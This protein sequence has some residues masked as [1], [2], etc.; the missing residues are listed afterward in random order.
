MI[1]VARTDCAPRMLQDWQWGIEID[2]GGSSRAARRRRSVRRCHTQAP[3]NGLN[4]RLDLSGELGRQISLVEHNRREAWRP[5]RWRSS[6]AEMFD[7]VVCRCAAQGKWRKPICRVISSAPSSHQRA[8]PEESCRTGGRLGLDATTR[9]HSACLC[10]GRGREQ[11][12]ARVWRQL[13]RRGTG[14]PSVACRLLR[15]HQ[16]DQR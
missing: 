12:Q 13:G 5:V 11:A 4:K 16:R 9:G 3:L 6:I 7:G 10:T 2:R 8:Q 15:R 1:N 14:M